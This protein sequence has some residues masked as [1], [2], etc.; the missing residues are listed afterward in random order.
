MLTLSLQDSQLTIDVL[1][2]DILQ[3]QIDNLIRS[4]HD[5]RSIDIAEECIPRV[6]AQSWKFSLTK[7]SP[8]SELI[9]QVIQ[10]VERVG[11]EEVKGRLTTPSGRTRANAAGTK[12]RTVSTEDAYILTLVVLGVGNNRSKVVPLLVAEV[13]GISVHI[14][15]YTHID[16]S[17]LS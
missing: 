7:I 12:A 1:I 8:T 10:G 16:Q 11:G 2:S 14:Y 6:P 13:A 3:S 4:N 5:L 9:T 17:E 15:I